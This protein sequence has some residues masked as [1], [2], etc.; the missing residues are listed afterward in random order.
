MR[1][2]LYV[3]AAVRRRLLVLSLVDPARPRGRRQHCG[4]IVTTQP[5]VVLQ[6]L[7]PSIIKTIDVREGERVKAGDVLATLDPTFATADVGALE[8][9]DRQPRRADRARRGRAGAD[10]PYD[11]DADRRR[12]GARATASCRRR[13]YAQRKAQFDA[14]MRAYDEQIAQYKATIAKL[15]N[16]EARYGDRA[17]LAKESRADAR[18]AWPRRRSAAGSICWPPPTRRPSC[19]AIS[20]STATAWSRRSTSSRRRPRRA[21]PLSSNGSAQTSQELVTARNAAR[22]RRRSSSKRPA[23]TRI[24]C[25]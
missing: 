18:D 11:A 10:R 24:W 22:H 16:N 4:Q 15:Q 21:T 8:A 3:L 19:C 2:T 6:A 7:D 12:G 14:Q 9:A 13:Y 20:N 1:V 25:A 23:S 17:K 5:T